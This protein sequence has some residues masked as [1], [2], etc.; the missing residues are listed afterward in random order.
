MPGE[1]TPRPHLGK[2]LKMRSLHVVRGCHEAVLTHTTASAISY[3]PDCAKVSDVQI[4]RGSRPQ[5][6]L[7]HKRQLTIGRCGMRASIDQAFMSRLSS[8]EAAEM[9]PSPE[10]GD[11]SMGSGE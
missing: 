8:N 11:S 1:R 7:V 9:S 2:M 4:S 3:V 10:R 5:V 6:T